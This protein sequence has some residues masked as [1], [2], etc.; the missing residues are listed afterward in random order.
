MPNEPDSL[1]LRNEALRREN[2]ELKK[3]LMEARDANTAKEV[4]LSSMSHDIRTP[5]NAIIGLT[6]LARKHIDE[7]ERVSDALNKI[8]VASNHLLNLINEVLDMSRIDS[9]KLTLE[10]EPFALS[11]LLH[12]TLVIIRPQAES[13]H[14]TLRFG[15][16]GIVYEGLIGDV[17]RLRQIFVNI[18]NNSVKYTNDG[19]EIR[20]NVTEEPDGDRVIL[21]FSCDDNG[22]GMSEE[23][24]RRMFEPFERASNSTQSG[25]EGTGLGMSIVRK[26]I[27]AMNGTITVRSAPGAGTSVRIRIP[28]RYETLSLD[29][30]AL[31][32]ANLLVIESSVR[33]RELFRTYLDEFRIHFTLA[34]SPS[35]AIAAMTDADFREDPFT[36]VILGTTGDGNANIYDIASYIRKSN[37]SLPIV[38]VSKDRWEDIQYRANRSGIDYFIPIPFFRKSLING[39]NAALTHSSEESDGFGAAPDLSGKRFLLVEDNIINMEIATELLA[40]TNATI[41]RCANGRE[42]VERFAAAEPNAYDLILMDIQMPIMDGY[43]ATRAIRALDRPDAKSV[44]IFAM[45]AN[46]FAEDIAK[47]RAAGMDGHIAKP[48]DVTKLMQTLRRFA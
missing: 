20:I 30:S 11:D 28:L 38:L 42:A 7:K 9:G 17:T 39:L 45:T 19:G 13:K 14:H 41:D 47:A 29:T 3:Q 8:G 36:G 10:E 22:I 44:R 40:A 6:A 24:L 26:L 12:D 15:A 37:P 1:V 16:D 34:E 23:F 33:R 35:D 43:T 31:R 27:D 25:V 48:I 4:F 32:N 2:D 46:I 5:M 21:V 18:A